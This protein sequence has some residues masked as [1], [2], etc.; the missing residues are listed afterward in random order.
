MVFADDDFY[1]DAEGVGGAK[2][3]EDAASGGAAGR[4]KVGYLYI[5]GEAFQRIV[6]C[7]ALGIGPA[8]LLELGLF[9]EDP[10]RSFLWGCGDLCTV[11]NQDG[12]RYAL[13]E[14]GDVV[15]IDERHVLPRAGAAVRAGVVEDADYGG[16]A[17]VEDSGYTA[18]AAAFSV[19]RSFVDQNLVTL[20]R[21]VDLVGRDEEIVFAIVAAVGTDEGVAVTMHVDA[22]CDEAVTGGAVLGWLID[23]AAWGASG[24]FGRGG[25]DA[26]LLA[27]GFD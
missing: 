10:V 1:V 12:L 6:A 14:R 2:D 8:S 3:F 4:G 17:A 27:L 15:S 9:A 20:H 5:D 26:P 21:A 18:G 23:V 22:S 25:G 16:V 13:V 11:R 19:A 24:A 7:V